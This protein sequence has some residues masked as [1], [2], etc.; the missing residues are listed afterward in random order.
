[1][2]SLIGDM[3]SV[4]ADLIAQSLSTGTVDDDTLLKLITSDEIDLLPLLHA[5][6]QVKTA[7]FPSTIKIQILNNVQSGHCS[8]DCKYCSQSNQAHNDIG[9]YKMKSETELLEEAAFAYNSGAVRYCMVLSGRD[10]GSSRVPALCTVVKKIKAKYPLEI[11][12]SAGFLTIVEA[13]QLV[14]AG[15]DRYNHNLNTSEVFY[16]EICTTHPYVVRLK[17]IQVA[18]EAGLEICSGVI[19]GMGESPKDIVGMVHQ[20]QAVNAQSIPI[21]FF[22]PLPGHRIK[23]VQALT[24]T[25]CLKILAAFRLALPKVEI[26]CAAGREYHLKSMQSLCL[27]PINSLF[28]QGYLTTGGDSVESTKELIEEAGFEV[29][30]WQ[31]QFK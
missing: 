16:S 18:K 28:A 4:Y 19:I 9:P 25:Y 10:I 12:V 22:I 14:E 17:T 6:Y 27:Y 1:M 3:Y 24:P 5:A 7:Y 29:E 2:D 26:R 13:I 30:M 8:E 21:N 31:T 15:V 23:N 20:L 11:C